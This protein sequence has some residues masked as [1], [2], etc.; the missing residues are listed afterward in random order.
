M[1]S[2][3]TRQ[4]ASP[5]E[6][7]TII[8]EWCDLN[9]I[10]ATV[11]DLAARG[12]LK[13]TEMAHHEFLFLSSKDYKLERTPPLPDASALKPF[14]QEMVEDIFAGGN[15]VLLSQ[16]KDKFYLHLPTIKYKV[17]NGLT[18]KGYFS[19]DPDTMRYSYNIL[20]YVL[21]FGS[22]FCLLKSV[23]WGIGV[24]FGSCYRLHNG[25]VDVGKNTQRS[26]SQTKVSWL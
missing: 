20:A 7:G 26:T 5:A 8:D 16:L 9:D 17:Y 3:G 24:F 10:V 18:N 4:L 25:L 13:I 23:S 15:E 2:S 19:Q 22:F 1:L 6:V 12:Y 14:E 21:G 11:I